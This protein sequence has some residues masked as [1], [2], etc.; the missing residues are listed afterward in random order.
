MGGRE[1]VSCLLLRFI[2]SAHLTRPPLQQV[3][4]V[5][6]SLRFHYSVM[7]FWSPTPPSRLIRCVATAAFVAGRGNAGVL[8][9]ILHL[10]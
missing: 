1:T 7:N 5:S 8:G 6:S 10:K 3:Q 4:P 2:Y 9:A